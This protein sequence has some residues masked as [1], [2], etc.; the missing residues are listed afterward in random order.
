MGLEFFR[1]LN[2]IYLY[3]DCIVLLYLKLVKFFVDCVAVGRA[4]EKFV[5]TGP[6]CT[7][8]LMKDA[9]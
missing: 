2:Y 7:N 3:D 9:L 1:F 8:R 6:C 5:A 4:Y